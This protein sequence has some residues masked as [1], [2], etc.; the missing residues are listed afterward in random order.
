MVR[1]SCVFVLIV[2]LAVVPFLQS[3]RGQL[4]T[5]GHPVRDDAHGAHFTAQAPS[6]VWRV[7][8]GAFDVYVIVEEAKDGTFVNVYPAVPLAAQ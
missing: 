4:P 2:S 6:T 8:Q 5:Q 3:L 7:N 1:P